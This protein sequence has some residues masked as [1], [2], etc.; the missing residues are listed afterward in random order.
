METLKH[1]SW[2]KQAA[3]F[4]YFGEA[5]VVNWVPNNEN[6][7]E[8]DGDD[9][10]TSLT[11]EWSCPNDD[12]GSVCQYEI[13]EAYCNFPQLK[14]LNYRHM[15]YRDDGGDIAYFDFYNVDE[16]TCSSILRDQEDNNNNR[17]S[18]YNTGNKD[19]DPYVYILG[20][21]HGSCTALP[22]VREMMY[23][24]TI[25]GLYARQCKVYASV[26]G[27]SLLVAAWYWFRGSRTTLMDVNKSSPTDEELL[28]G[29]ASQTQ[30]TV[31]LGVPT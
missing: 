24:V 9:V 16:Y 1:E 29:A 20:T 26:A 12:N 4:D 21:C 28:D 5:Y 10:M 27:F 6:V 18:A 2:Y 13:E 17:Q 22:L 30:A 15:Y 7:N 14:Y 19:D 25:P 3:G 23:K 8:D 11:L 31:E